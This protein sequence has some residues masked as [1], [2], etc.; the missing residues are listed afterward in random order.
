MKLP[1]KIQ[2]G[3]EEFTIQYEDNL[4]LSQN[5]LSIL[6]PSHDY[7]KLH[8]FL[9]PRVKARQIFYSLHL[10]IS[11][12]VSPDLEQRQQHALSHF[13]CGILRDNPG[14]VKL[15]FVNTLHISG[16]DYIVVYGD[17]PDRSNF[18]SWS[19][20]S[21]KIWVNH[22]GNRSIRLHSLFHEIYH[23]AYSCLD[24]EYAERDIDLYSWFLCQVLHQNQ[25]W[26]LIEAEEGNLDED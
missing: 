2:I 13:I 11:N 21:M 26:W 1:D 4:I 6:Y 16:D 12:Q 5:R 8:R 15:E 20:I 17:P 22:T 24:F 7:V 23:I 9:E 14:L 18:A 25:I 3:F 10:W 19:N